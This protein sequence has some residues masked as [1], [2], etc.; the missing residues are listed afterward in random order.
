MSISPEL[1]ARID[2]MPHEDMKEGVIRIL[3][4]PGRP[5]GTDEQVFLAA[6]NEYLQ[7]LVVNT[8][9]RM[10]RLYKWRDDEVLAFI[11]YFK[12]IRP[13]MY[14]EYLGQ[15]RNGRQIDRDLAWDM[16]RLGELWHP[17]LDWDDY[18]EL[19]SKVRDYAQAHLI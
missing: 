6:L 1:Q 13:Q 14:A 18:E 2:A 4:G 12:E 9:E 3:T 5:S 10:A 11:E 8:P 15:E 16:R 7:S 19:F 17:G